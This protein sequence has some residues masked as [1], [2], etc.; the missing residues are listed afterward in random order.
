M[1]CWCFEFIQSIQCTIVSCI[2][3]QTNTHFQMW[4]SRG[5]HGGHQHGPRGE[6]SAHQA[7]LSAFV[8]ACAWTSPHGSG[9]QLPSAWRTLLPNLHEGA[10]LCQCCRI[11][12]TASRQTI[13]VAFFSDYGKSYF[14]DIGSHSQRIAWITVTKKIHLI[15]THTHTYIFSK[16]WFNVNEFGVM[17]LHKTSHKKIYLKIYIYYYWSKS[18]VPQ[19]FEW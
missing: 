5:I 2:H 10:F 12:T 1:A 18:H 14:Q 13:M 4:F 15:H 19:T 8:P 16:P 3:K 9:G 6:G 11:L 7:G 17:H